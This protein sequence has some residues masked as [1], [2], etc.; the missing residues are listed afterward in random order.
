[1]D[2]VDERSLELADVLPAVGTALVADLGLGG[3]VCAEAESDNEFR[4]VFTIGTVGETAQWQPTATG[5][6][7]DETLSIALQRGS[8]AVGLLRIKA[9][10]PLG[11][12]D[13][14]VVRIAAE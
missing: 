13:L 14:R 4:D 5:L 10:R 8:R 7:A 11:V 9:G 1:M 2:S 3:L 12:D 6:A